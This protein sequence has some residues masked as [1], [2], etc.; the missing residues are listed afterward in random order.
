ME[1]IFS[2][3]QPSGE[4]HLGNYLGAVHNWVRLQKQ[5]RT[6]ICLVDYHA[7]TQNYE[8]KELAP[9]TLEMASELIACGIDPETTTL[10]VQSG[11]REHTELTWVLNT[12][13]PF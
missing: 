1:T 4:L 13:T 6:I 8:V 10:F 7:I 5:Y 9:R 12:V 2:G 11:V 3:I